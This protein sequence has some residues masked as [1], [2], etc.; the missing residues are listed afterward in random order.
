MVQRVSAERDRSGHTDNPVT[1]WEDGDPDA[2]SN[3]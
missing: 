3:A 1:P 2:S